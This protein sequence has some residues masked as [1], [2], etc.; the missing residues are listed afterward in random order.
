MATSTGVV[1]GALIYILALSVLLLVLIVFF[2]I[3]FLVRY[4]R[5]ATRSRPNCPR[6]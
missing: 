1:D 6:A 5:R 3:F 4:R 2:M